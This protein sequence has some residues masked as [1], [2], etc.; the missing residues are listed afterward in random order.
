MCIYKNVDLADL[1]NEIWKDV[2]GYEDI[3][4]V[5]NLGRVYFRYLK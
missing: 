1:P 5:S 3:Y 4:Q 2:I